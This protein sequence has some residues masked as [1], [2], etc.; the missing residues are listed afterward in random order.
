MRKISSP[1][2]MNKQLKCALKTPYNSIKFEKGKPKI[3]LFTSVIYSSLPCCIFMLC[4][5]QKKAVYKLKL[6]PI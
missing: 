3:T 1:K 5:M 4:V 6:F 2:N